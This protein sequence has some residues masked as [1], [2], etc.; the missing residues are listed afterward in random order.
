MKWVYILL[1]L[2]GKPRLTNDKLDKC[3]M[4]RKLVTDPLFIGVQEMLML[5]LNNTIQEWQFQ[6]IYLQ[7]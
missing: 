5:S 6:L 4:K 7:V 1:F 2:L 3:N